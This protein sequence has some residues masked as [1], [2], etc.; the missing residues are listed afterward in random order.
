[1]DVHLFVSL[2]FVLQSELFLPNKAEVCVDSWD[3]MAD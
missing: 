1:M 3:H 2:L